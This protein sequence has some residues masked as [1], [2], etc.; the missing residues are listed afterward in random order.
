MTAPARIRLKGQPELLGADL[1][2]PGDPVVGGVP[3]GGGADH[4]GL[5]GGG[6]G[7]GA[8]SAARRAS[9]TLAEMGADMTFE[10]SATKAASRSPTWSSAPAL[11]RASSCRPSARP[12]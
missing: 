2:V 11:S 8:E 5:C 12:A 4:A 3:A 9:L 1:V 6:G 7:R 10:K